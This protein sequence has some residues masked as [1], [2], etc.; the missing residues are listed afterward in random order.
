M[1]KI[2]DINYASFLNAA[3]AEKNDRPSRVIV[4]LIVFSTAILII[5]AKFAYLDEITRGAGR[6]VPSSKNQVVQNL[7]GGIIEEILVKPGD[8][9]KKDQALLKIDNK[10]FES[11]YE[12]GELKIS[13]LRMKTARLSAEANLSEFTTEVKLAKEHPELYRNEKILFETDMGFLDNQLKMI[14]H[15]I[16]QKTNEI[17]EARSRIKILEQNSG[18]LYQQLSM[19]KPLV[20]RKIES[21]TEYIK[22]ERE[23]MNLKERL[24]SSR[25]SITRAESAIQELGKKRDEY[26]IS[27]KTRAQK[28]LNDIL[29]SISQY[30]QRQ[31]AAKDQVART[32]VKSPVNGIVKQIHINTVGG[33][34]RPGMD[35]I[36][37]V[38]LDD[39]LLA[40]VQIRP[41]DIAYI[42]PGQHA[43]VKITAYDYSIY[44]GLNGKLVSIS[45]DTFNDERG[46]SYYLVKIQTEK[47]YLGPAEK[48]LKIIPGMTV[49]A[50]ILTGKKSVLDYLIK[51]ILKTKQTA[52]SER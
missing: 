33:V 29:S 39:T 27:F 9:V 14:E 10:K 28:E 17:E 37:I 24:E 1:S 5:W 18:L 13:E 51:P 31:S 46:Q 16:A 21:K 25:Y 30:G 3:I 12:E 49:S 15:Q 8:I 32:L 44:G 47:N 36:E 50:D 43:T 45:A 35:L 38:Q 4:A 52:L 7:E 22:L 48:P 42:H 23:V 6:I 20:E 2:Q 40:E 19:M 34:V 41:S 26:I 11:T